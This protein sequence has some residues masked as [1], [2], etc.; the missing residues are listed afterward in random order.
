MATPA[1]WVAVVADSTLRNCAS[2]AVNWRISAILPAHAA[3]AAAGP[4]AGIRGFTG[5]GAGFPG[6]G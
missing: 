6:A 3:R 1:T 5:T 2:S 4:F